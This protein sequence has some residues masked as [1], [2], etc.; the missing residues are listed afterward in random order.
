MSYIIIPENQK[1]PLE[2]IENIIKYLIIIELLF[3]L[4]DIL[5]LSISFFPY[6][7]FFLF[8]SFYNYSQL[9]SLSIYLFIHFI[10][11]HKF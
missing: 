11:S 10:P 4:F 5:S 9:Y 1:Y 3:L 7:H 2:Q 8:F 6:F